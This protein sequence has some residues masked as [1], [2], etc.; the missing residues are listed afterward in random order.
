MNIADII[1][2]AKQGFTPGSI[3]EILS[4]SVTET[5]LLPTETGT[6]TK[7]SPTKTTGTET[8]WTSTDTNVSDDIK[9]N[10]ATSQPKV[11]EE[12][13]GNSEKVIALQDEIEKLKAELNDIQ[14]KHKTEI[15]SIQIQ[16]KKVDISGEQN[17]SESDLLSDVLEKFI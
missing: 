6:G 13:K 1:I 12:N 17:K 8:K 4:L 2:L 5:N 15:E 3:K 10:I 9:M 14:K 7:C 16:N 11:K